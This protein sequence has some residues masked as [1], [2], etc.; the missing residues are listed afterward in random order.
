[1]TGNKATIH[2]APDLVGFYF[3]LVLFLVSCGLAWGCDP[4]GRVDKFFSSEFRL[5]SR[6]N[7]P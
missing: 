5:I 4:T 3:I 1:M 6:P 7:W 2:P